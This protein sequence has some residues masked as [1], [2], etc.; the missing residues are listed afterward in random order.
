MKKILYGLLGWLLYAL[1]RMPF[2]ILYALS[3]VMF[4]IAYYVVRY[5]HRVVMDNI[6]ASFPDFSKEEC[7]RIAR[8]FYR[9]LADYFF[10]TIKLH[11]ISDDEMRRRLVYEN[12]EIVD[13]L[14]SQNRSIVCYF[15][16]CFNWEWAP[17]I[18]LWTKHKP[19]DKITF[20]QVYRPLR[21]KWF[22][23]F[24]LSLRSRFQSVSY[25]KATVFRDLLKQKRAGVLDICGF[26]SDQKPSHGDPTHVMRFLNHPT[27]MITGTETLARRLDMAVVYMDIYKLRRG[28]YKIVMRHI[29]SHPNELPPMAITE[30]YASMLQQTI[31]RNPALWFWSHKRW[32]IPVKLPEKELETI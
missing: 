11:H 31:N 23:D 12:V 25:P 3:D 28:H 5:R 24:F 18:T 21:N 2:G 19:S 22:D 1:S 13:E 4:V 26:M 14:F 15:A 16:H 6:A 27:A 20:S 8:Q 9:N 10:E 17:S 30:R 7:R 32:K 29:T